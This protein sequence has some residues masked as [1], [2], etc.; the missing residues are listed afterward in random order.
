LTAVCT[1][2]ATPPFLPKHLIREHRGDCGLNVRAACVYEPEIVVTL[3][4]Q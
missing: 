1:A 3:F 4:S 2:Y